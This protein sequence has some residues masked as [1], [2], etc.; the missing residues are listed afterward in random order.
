MRERRT[1]D[2]GRGVRGRFIRDRLMT[3]VFTGAGWVAIVFIAL[4]FLFTFREALPI[5]IEPRVS[6]EANLHEFFVKT[7]PGESIEERYV[8]Q[9]V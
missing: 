7:L 4:I 1:I 2:L 8:W 3:G 9:P 6:R 5:F